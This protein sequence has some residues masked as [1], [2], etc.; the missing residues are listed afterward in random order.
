MQVGLAFSYIPITYV[1]GDHCSALCNCTRVWCC[2][3]FL[4]CES[5][6]SLCSYGVNL[7]KEKQARAKQQQMVLG[8]RVEVFWLG[9]LLVDLFFFALVSRCALHGPYQR[10]LMFPPV[11]SVRSL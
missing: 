5:A 11:L 1:R 6:S 10:A 4:L 7:V 3:C 2:L 8:L 9:N